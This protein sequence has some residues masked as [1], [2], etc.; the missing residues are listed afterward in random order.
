MTISRYIR[1]DI[2]A[3]TPYASARDE[4]DGEAAIFLDA[5]ENALDPLGMTHHRYPHPGYGELKAAI[6]QWRQVSP[7]QV[8]VGNGSDEAIDLLIRATCFPGKDA[9]MILPPT[10][11]MYAVQAR[12]QGV[13]VQEV[14]LT[15]DFQLDVEAILQAVTPNTR[16]LFLCSPNN[17]TGNVLAADRVERLLTQFSG[18][19]VVDEA[20][21]DFSDSPSWVQ[22]LATFPNLVVLQTFS[23]AAGLAGIRLGMA[24]GHPELIAVLNKIKFPYNVNRLTVQAALQALQHQDVIQ[25]SIQ[26]IRNEREKLVR[27]LQALPGVRKVYPSQANFLLVQFDQAQQVYRELQQ[28][29]IIVRDRSRLPRCEGCLRITVGTPEEN[30]RLIQTLQEIMQQHETR[31]IH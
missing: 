10:Y 9:I 6:A 24:F 2:L 29:G 22:R 11:G 27:A 8:F 20:Y 21:I 28:N 25:R 14:V 19:V 5:N 18:I 30:Q 13:A 1:P 7:D 3:L 16:L 12:I 17:P 31:P 4:F 23:K 15:A 26:Q